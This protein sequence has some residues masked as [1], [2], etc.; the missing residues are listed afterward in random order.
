MNR[1]A[2]DQL[3]IK[4]IAYSF[5]TAAS[6]LALIPF[7]ALVMSSLTSER[8]IIMNGFQLIPHEISLSAYQLIFSNPAKIINAYK[9]TLLVAGVGT[10]VSLFF[11]SMT[12]YVLFNKSVKYRNQLAFFL[13]FTELFNGGLVAFFIVV[14]SV[15]GLKNSLLVLILV[16]LFHVFHILI[17]RNF[18]NSVP[19]TLIESAVLDGANDFQTFIRI[20]LPLTK[21]ALAVI[22]LFTA[23]IYWNDW[24]TAMMFIEKPAMRPLQ[25]VLYLILSSVNLAS[26]MVDNV[27]TMNAPKE[28]LKL[29]M[30]VIATGPIMFAYPFIQKYFVKGI[31]I[32]AVKG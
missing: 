7:V 30:V 9:V 1:K 15:L 23:L 10:V 20:M 8:D 16:P 6:L 13:Y 5:V 27:P 12:A 24:W 18:M 31:T 3:V 17:L 32:G 14:G 4:Y 22:S 2:Y 11:S 28:S 19:Y 29:A 26:N 21:P 25:Y